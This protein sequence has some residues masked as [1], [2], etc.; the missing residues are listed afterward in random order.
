MPTAL[1]SVVSTPALVRRERWPSFC[2]RVLARSWHVVATIEELGPPGA[3]SP[4]TLLPGALDESLLLLHEPELRAF[5][6]VCSHRSAPLLS[7][8]QAGGPLRCPYHGRQ[9]T[10]DGRCRSAP[11]FG[12]LGRADDLV[13]VQ[14][15]RWGPLV[16]AA[17]D[18]AMP[19]PELAELDGLWPEG[20]A[21]DPSGSVDYEL[22]AHALLWMENYLEGLHIPFV[23]AG[24]NRAI[25]WKGYRTE[26]TGWSSVQLAPPSGAGPTVSWR[27]Q[28]WAGVYLALF[29]TT[30]VNVYPWGVSLNLVQP[31]GPTRTRVRY[32][33]W[34]ARPELLDAGAGAGLDVVEAEDDAVVEA[35][36]R[37]VRSRFARPARLAGGWEE[38]VAALHTGLS[39]L[40][41][42]EE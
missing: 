16:F 29:P 5:A 30:M 42:T 11:G 33:R 28:T 39:A 18:P 26:R 4:V 36:Q 19:F 37:G 9:F 8:P 32:R 14:L 7:A 20:A 40:G 23:H 17:V 2:D 27:G 41:F 1:P 22:E 15:A 13:P 10:L 6:N 25:E 31:L 35:V 3:V 12:E 38:G 21:F 24:L 34:V